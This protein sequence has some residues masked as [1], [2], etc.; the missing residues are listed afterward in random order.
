MATRIERLYEKDFSAWTRHQARALRR[1]AATRPNADLDLEHLIDEV[2]DLGKSERDAARSQLRTII[3]HCLKLE[4]SRAHD[5]RAGWIVSITHARVALEDK[6]SRSLRRDLTA[7]L[8]RIYDQ[9]RRQAAVA[10]QAHAEDDVAA[11]LPAPCPYRL[12]DLLARDWL[13]VSRADAS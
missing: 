1:L 4:H 6:L 13:P 9:A 11:A 7:N 10:L 2:R 3:E 12:F 5:P 8:A